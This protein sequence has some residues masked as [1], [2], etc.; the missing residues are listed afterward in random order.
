M[1]HLN[2]KN[3]LV[4]LLAAALALKAGFCN[5]AGEMTP[6]AATG[7]TPERN[8]EELPPLPPPTEAQLAKGREILKKISHVVKI[9]PLQEA[10]AVMRVFSFTELDTT[11]FPTYVQVQPKGQTTRGAL[12]EELVGTGFTHIRVDPLVRNEKVNR[13]ASFT[14]SLNI[15]EACISLEAVKGE[16]GHAAEIRTMPVRDIHPIKRPK[17]MHD[18]GHITFYP[19][20]TPAGDIG[21]AGFSFEYQACA[22]DFGFSYLNSHE[23]T[24]R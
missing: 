22:M 2:R 15:N 12:P 4:H 1:K 16:F 19:L 20:A 3:A 17:R 13:I 9:V 5:A 10:A 18:I 14:V 24:S 11:I 23:R 8:N 7:A 6:G 21:R